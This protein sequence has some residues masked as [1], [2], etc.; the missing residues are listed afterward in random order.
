[1]ARI[2]GVAVT[3]VSVA[4]IEF[5]DTVTAG[6][7]TASKAVVA[8]ANKDVTGF[9]NV[10]GTGALEGATLVGT[11]SVTTGSVINTG[12]VGTAGT[13]V[14]AVEYGDGHMH[15]TVL[16]ISTTLPAIAGG[17]ALSIGNLIYTLP[18]GAV[19]V[20]SSYISMAITQSQGNI[21]AD[22]PDV[23]LGTTIA[24]GA[25]ALLSDTAGAENIMTGQTA[26]DCNGTATV[27]A[28]GTQL[29]I[30]AGEDHTVY[31]NTA[32]DWAAS[33]D[34]AAT[35]VGTVTLVWSFLA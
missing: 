6:T 34:A 21:T 10:T 23:G 5:L 22:T 28:I 25:N 30:E 26:A 15:K 18:A 32:D 17:A 12:N 19:V 8:D 2:A 13:G 11:T 20:H 3:T 29:V 16:T 1:M 31:F 35:L 4:E 27:N 24:A 33:G 7:V 9:R 14:T